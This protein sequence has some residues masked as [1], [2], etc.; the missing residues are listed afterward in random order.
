MMTGKTFGWVGPRLLVLLAPVALLLLAAPARATFPGANGLIAVDS[1]D[2]PGG[3][4][5]EYITPEG[6]LAHWISTP[7]D[8]YGPAWSP[9]GTRTAYS[10]FD[11]V[12]EDEAV[13]VA[14]ADGSGG[15]RI[16]PPL[17]HS[18]AWSADG[19][20]IAYVLPEAFCFCDEKLAVVNSDGTMDSGVTN[21][22]PGFGDF[23]PD[24]SPDGTKIAFLRRDQAGDDADIYTVKP[25]GTGL[26]NITN[27]PSR[28]EGL[29]S[30]SPDATK[31][32]FSAAGNVW[33]MNPDGSSPG[34]LTTNGV[35]HTP[36]WSPDG[37]KILF[38]QGSDLYLMNIDGSDQHP[39]GARAKTPPARAGGGSWQPLMKSSPPPSYDAPER[40]LVLSASLV[41]NFRQTIST[42]Q[43]QSRMGTPSMHGAPLAFESCNPPGYSPGTVA[44]IGPQS[45]EGRVTLT[46]FGG[47]DSLSDGDQADVAVRT[48]LTDVQNAL[49]ADY[50]PSPANDVTLV[51]RLRISDRNN[52]PSGAGGTVADVNYAIPFACSPSS[53]AALGSVCSTYTSIDAVTPGA[54]V[55]N[56]AAVMQTFRLRLNDAGV[57]GTTGDPDDRIFATQGIYI[58]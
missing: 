50:N 3:P 48:F 23:F 43:C 12:I 26:I 54:I 24:W 30:W 42:T 55:E 45:V 57:N 7:E 37:R 8:P 58:P 1:I 17:A 19:T 18:P 22:P 33:K 49:G 38:H 4:D 46:V 41:P 20:K 16:G 11:Q 15:T 35:S 28:D 9:D 14:D 31:L 34:M 10:V 5:I 56:K 53:N 52:G 36:I 51:A 47:N 25:D 13:H 21:P 27:T 6:A 44:D 39:I 29:P 2:A 40:A 32:A